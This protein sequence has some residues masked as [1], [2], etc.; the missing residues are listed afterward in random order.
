MLS[1]CHP[2]LSRC[3]PKLSRCYPKL[4]RCHPKLSRCHP[5]HLPSVQNDE[6]RLGDVLS[7][8]I[9][10]GRSGLVVR[11]RLRGRRVVKFEIRFHRRSTD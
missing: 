9:S 1:R 7:Q 8:F 3:H 10:R 6:V 2:K 11:S 4:S 5:L